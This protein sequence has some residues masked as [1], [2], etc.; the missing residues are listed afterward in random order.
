MTSQ[1]KNIDIPYSVRELSTWSEVPE[2]FIMMVTNWGWLNNIY[3][4]DLAQNDRLMF[5]RKWW[6]ANV[7]EDALKRNLPK[8]R[9]FEAE[10]LKLDL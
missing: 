8:K 9:K 10:Q 6:A 7:N 1:R 5:I 3:G 4:A 2:V